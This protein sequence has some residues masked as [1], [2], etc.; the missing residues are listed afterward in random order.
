MSNRQTE[1]TRQLEH[2]KLLCRYV[3]ALDSGDFKTVAAVLDEAEHDQRLEKLILE[4]NEVYAYE[5]DD[6]G[7]ESDAETVRQ[8][9]R[10]HIPSGLTVE[11]EEKDLLPLTVGD[12]VARL[13]SDAML[14]GQEV[15]AVIQQ[16]RQS[17]VGLPDDLSKRGVGQFF[18]RLG[19]SLSE[20]FQKL[21]RETAIFLSMGREQYA[22]RLAATRRQRR[23]SKLDTP[24]KDER[25]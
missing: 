16:L 19:F 4:I 14:K 13:Q 24:N 1:D 5:D 12:V 17:E 22:A 9:L 6:A 7:K 25:K 11:N 8:L 21:F 15:R 10:K 18:E 23:S 2:E 20:Q 3:C